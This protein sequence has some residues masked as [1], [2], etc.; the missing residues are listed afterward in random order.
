MIRLMIALIISSIFFSKAYALDQTMFLIA[1]PRTLAMGGAGV[2]LADDEYALFQNP[3]GLAGLEERG[4]RPVAVGIEGSLDTYA[5]LGSIMALSGNLSISALNTFMG[6]DIAFRADEVPMIMLPHFALAYIFDTQFSLNQYNR[7]NPTFNLGSMIT[8]GV[9]GGT[10]WSFKE[11][12]HPT[13]EFRV[14]VAFKFLFRKGAYNTIGTAGLLQAS[15]D[16]VGYLKG[17][18]GNFGVG[19]GGDVGVQYIKKL[20]TT[21]TVS[22][23]S[24]ITD[25]GGTHFT[26]STAMPIPMVWSTGLG[27]KKEMSESLKVSY[28]LDMRDILLDTALSNKIYTGGEISLGMLDLYAGLNQLSPTYGVG[29]DAWLLKIM[30]LS[31]AEQ[32]GPAYGQ[33]SSRRDMI[34]INFNMPI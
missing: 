16:G 20:D 32:L 10:S 4:F 7:V 17:L 33:Q 24:S 29:F 3:A 26:A 8:H 13:D 15:G 1:Q 9:Q 28:G 34:Q 5:S 21:T 6:K 23:G 14:G 30:L 25:V 22:L 2:G 31:Y 18:V 19:L 27:Y 11:G 12:R